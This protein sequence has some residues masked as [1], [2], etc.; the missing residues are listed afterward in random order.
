M[1]DLYKSDP[2]LSK[3]TAIFF[4]GTPFGVI[5]II[6]VYFIKT[7]TENPKTS[8]RFLY[9]TLQDLIELKMIMFLSTVFILGVA[10]KLVNGYQTLFLEKESDTP[11]TV[12][13]LILAICAICQIV[14]FSFSSQLKKMLGGAD[15]FGLLL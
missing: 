13:G 9:K 2:F 12:I 15:P 7:R 10:Y 11:K 4:C 3:Y 1:V 8:L 6:N 14:V 5:M